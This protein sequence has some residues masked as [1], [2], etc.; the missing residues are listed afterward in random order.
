VQKVAGTRIE[1]GRDRG[2]AVTTGP[3]VIDE[4]D[5]TQ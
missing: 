2:A 3:A 4:G 5:R 1:V